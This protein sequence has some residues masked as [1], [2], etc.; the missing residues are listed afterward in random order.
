MSIYQEQIKAFVKKSVNVKAAFAL[1]EE[2]FK[3]LH[4]K[5]KFDVDAVWKEVK[6]QSSQKTGKA[7]DSKK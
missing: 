5:S 4:T 7:T 3:K 2:G 1:G 6:K